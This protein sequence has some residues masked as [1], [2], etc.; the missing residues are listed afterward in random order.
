MTRHDM[1]VVEKSSERSKRLARVRRARAEI[2]PGSQQ[3]M[4]K[5][6][7]EQPR[8]TFF[9]ERSNK[10]QGTC[11]MVQS[12]LGVRVGCTS[13]DF[14]AGRVLIREY[15]IGDLLSAKNVCTE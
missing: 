11:N 12:A 1:V 6:W 14:F 9:Q 10:T 13:W 8:T 7:Q 4:N 3:S 15:G 2:G 5:R